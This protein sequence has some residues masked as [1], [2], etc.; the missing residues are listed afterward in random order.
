MG[1]RNICHLVASNNVTQLQY[2]LLERPQDI[3]KTDR[4]GRSPLMKAT[5]SGLSEVVALLLDRGANINHYDLLRKTALHYAIEEGFTD[6]ATF[7]IKRGADINFQ[8]LGG[9]TPLDECKSFS[10]TNMLKT[11]YSAHR[12]ASTDYSTQVGKSEVP[13][14]I[15][16]DMRSLF[17]ASPNNS[18][19]CA[20]EVPCLIDSDM[21]SLFDASPDNSVYCANEVPCM[22]DSDLDDILSENDVLFLESVSVD[23]RDPSASCYPDDD[24]VDDDAPL[25]FDEDYDAKRY[26]KER[27]DT[28]SKHLRTTDVNEDALSSLERTSSLRP[29]SDW[30]LD[31]GWG[32]ASERGRIPSRS[33]RSS[34][35]WTSLCDEEQERYCWEGSKDGNHKC[36][37]CSK[38]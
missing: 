34:V 32:A 15:D 7:L 19:Y 29:S 30:G 27:E 2:H 12:H 5:K 33:S 16:S 10:I 35:D 3:N 1:V 9:K 25:L 18:V 31:V 26:G 20:N 24:E 36:R 8:N 22:I 38:K 17:D 37:R 21:R 28:R 23:N 14:L 13:C 4:Y 11:A 6:V